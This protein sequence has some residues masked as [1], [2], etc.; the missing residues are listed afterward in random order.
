M[1]IPFTRILSTSLILLLGASA[2]RAVDPTPIV[3]TDALA[4]AHNQP[5]AWPVAAG[6]WNGKAARYCAATG[7]LVFE[8]FRED[9]IGGSTTPPSGTITAIGVTSYY[10]AGPAT[11]PDSRSGTTV[12][13]V[14]DRDGSNPVGI[15][16]QDLVD[17]V[18][19]VQIYE[20][21]PSTS[22][23]PNLPVRRTGAKIYANQNKDLA[24]WTPDGAWL[25]AGVEMPKHALTHDAGNSEVGGFNNLWAI[26]ADGKIW[27]QLTRYENTWTHYDPVAMIPYA[28]LQSPGEQYSAAGN[29]VPFKAYFGSAAGTPPPASGTMRPTLGNRF[30]GGRVPLA[31]AE[32]VGYSGAY[33][34]GGPLSLALAE[35]V[36]SGGLPALANYRRSLAP[37]PSNPSGVGGW[38]NPGGATVIGA[39]YEP[40]AFS[41]DDSELLIA[42]DVFLQ[43]TSIASATRQKL[44]GYTDVLA[45]KWQAPHA[46]VNLTARTANYLYTPNGFNTYGYWEEPSI[47]ATINGAQFVP[48]GSSAN[49]SAFGLD[50]WLAPRDLASTFK[51]I[52]T[53]NRSGNGQWFCYPTAFDTQNRTAYLSVVPYAAFTNPPG[54][55]ATWTFPTITSSTTANGTIGQPFSYTITSSQALGGFAATGLPP[56]L[57]LG[58]SGVISGMPTT[59]G[60]YPV[61]LTATG[62]PG[63][64]TTTMTMSPVGGTTSGTGTTGP[65][66]TVGST[67]GAPTDTGGGGGGGGGSGCG[68]GGGLAAIVLACW[69]LRWRRSVR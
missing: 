65:G 17:G 51:R 38:A 1:P 26:S 43:S 68:L 59:A 37:T 57:S 39:G 21:A 15:G 53:V 48:F 42:S 3:G 27:V 6:N 13:Y 12:L 9:L 50:M 4:V 54:M 30:V 67:T 22:A 5:A 14:S 8:T 31:V 66:S 40:W 29:D 55:I 60:T 64:V 25:V 69:S 2:I 28:A 11:G 52:T 20:T 32:R 41:D 56:G 34:W 62:M 24:A 47:Y 10:D 36:F 35:V 19:G 49:L 63:S 16:I 33:T 46:L 44:Q 61:V 7:K 58:G 45:W 23:T 18:G